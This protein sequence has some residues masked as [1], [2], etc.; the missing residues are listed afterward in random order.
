MELVYIAAAIMISGAALATG[1]GFGLLG[2][3]LLDSTARQ[4]ELGDQLQTKTFIMAGLLDAVPMIG[5]GIAMYLIFVVA[6]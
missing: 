5:V 3:K 4:P 2:G 6:G 1:I